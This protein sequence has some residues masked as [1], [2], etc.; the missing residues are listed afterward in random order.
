MKRL[1]AGL[2]VV[3]R[4]LGVAFCL[5]FLIWFASGIV[6]VFKRMPEF[7]Q[8]ERLARLPPLDAEGIRLTPA[9]ALE[10]AGLQSPPERVLLTTYRDR[11]VY[12]LA[13]EF[14][15]ITVFADD[16]SYLELVTPEDAVAIAGVLFPEH[17][18]TVRHL[19]SIGEPDQWTITN[20]FNATGALHRVALGDPAGTEVYV[21]E[22]TGEIVMKTD[23]A[24]RFWGYLGPVAHWFYFTPLRWG[25][26]PLWNDLVVYGS[27]VGC[28]LCI[29]GLVIGLYRFSITR[30]FMRSTSMS[31]YVGWLR[32][33]HYAGLLF[34]AVTLTWTFSGLLTMTPWNLFPAAGPSR[35]QVRAV[36]GEGVA[37]DRVTVVPAVAIAELQPRFAPK[38]IELLQFMGAPFYAAYERAGIS[39]RAHQDAARFA[40]PDARPRRALVSADGARPGVREA[41]TREELL[42]AARAAMAELEPVEVAWLTD[43]DAYYYDRTGGRRLPVLR[44]KFNDPEET[45]LYLDANDGSIA[46][47]EVRG[48]RTER[49]LYQGLHSLDFPWLYAMPWAWYA[50]IIGLSL[51]GVALSL[52]S[53]V[54]A[55][56]FL[57]G[58]ARVVAEPS[59]TAAA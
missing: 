42:A 17:R 31:P 4:Y 55:W 47:A 30:R 40:A 48:S 1:I 20:R 26:A 13:L 57:R 38:E 36:R 19:D 23:R 29:L 33:H 21:A 5:I 3:H 59:S 2:I 54:I 58:K 51:S 28:V 52:T 49:W 45:W 35:A 12:R 8:E 37:L 44:A 16:G 41:F 15:S 53:L 39:A 6:M 7:S 22:A 14:G 32:W 24:S 9:Q 10:A 11:P 46:L 50:V 27:V 18:A 34:G 56:R 43:Y 25:Q